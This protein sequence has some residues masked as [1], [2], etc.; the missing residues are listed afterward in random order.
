[1]TNEF[2]GL[3]CPHCHSFCWYEDDGDLICDDCGYMWDN[4]AGITPPPYTL[5]EI[6]AS[7]RAHGYDP[8]QLRF[9]MP[10]GDA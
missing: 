2:D 3:R 6:D 10:D 7:L 8:D 4:R 5:E 1:M 9:T